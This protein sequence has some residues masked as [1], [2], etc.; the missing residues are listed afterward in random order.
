[1]R[2]RGPVARVH[3]PG[4]GRRAAEAVYLDLPRARYRCRRAAEESGDKTALS[5]AQAGPA[6]PL[7]GT[8]EAPV[9]AVPVA[10]PA[11][12]PC[13]SRRNRDPCL[14]TRSPPGRAPAI[15]RP[16]TPVEK[17][18]AG[19]ANRARPAT[20]ADSSCHSAATIHIAPRTAASAPS[21][22]RG[23]P[24]T[25][26]PEFRPFLRASA[27]PRDD[28]SDRTRAPRTARRRTPRA[29]PRAKEPR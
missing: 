20:P 29:V 21:G 18:P 8:P 11:I 26:A 5:K 15:L 17:A 1:M 7:P 22:F 12:A 3:L 28:G 24:G 16:S 14:P 6:R 10:W 19:R 27:L 2:G 25:R 4:D 23:S 9:P 13:L